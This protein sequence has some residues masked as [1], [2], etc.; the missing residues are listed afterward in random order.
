MKRSRFTGKREIYPCRQEIR[1]Q[2]FGC[3]F[4]ATHQEEARTAFG[5]YVP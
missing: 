4:L 1:E 5:C 2:I 3:G